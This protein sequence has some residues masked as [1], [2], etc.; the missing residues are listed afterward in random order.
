[1]SSGFSRKA[2]PIL[3]VVLAVLVGVLALHRLAHASTP[4]SSQVNPVKM[5]HE[6]GV[7]ETTDELPLIASNLSLPRYGDFK[8]GSDR[9]RWMIDQLRAMGVPN[10]LL[11]LVARVDFDVQ[12]D[13]RFEACWG[14]RDKMAGVQLEMDMSKD[15]EMRTALGAEGFR[16][17]DQKN[18]LW[19]AMSTEVDVTAS[20][21]AALY[22]LKKKLQQ[23]QL[24]LEQAKMNG[25][26]DDAAINDASDQAQADFNRQMKALLGDDR[27]AKSQQLDD[28]FQS[29]LLRSQLAGVNPSD[30]QF[31]ELFKAQQ[32]WNTS[33]LKLDPTSPDYATQLQALNNARDQEYQQVLGAD[34]CATLQKVQD[35]GYT[36]MK[37]YA[38]LWGL[39]DGKIDYVY[40]AM[41]NYEASM[42]ACQAQA[43]ALQAQGQTVDWNA[44]NKNLQQLT[45]QTGQTLQNYLG[46]DSFNKL[47]RNHLFLFNQAQSPQ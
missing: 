9:R 25:T 45:D 43:A 41:K 28:A 37:K 21:A 6:F 23:R 27:Y 29:D 33:Q 32:Q 17:W 38:N 20:E 1:M 8:S 2:S 15:G 42:Q 26:M 4:P 35:P 46:Q 14:D 16:Q 39:D 30:S 3:N 10:D 18:M 5:T 12:W 36:E 44:V 19:E 40:G 22:D 31:Q 34:A 24:D 11:A 13:S 7:K 47:Q